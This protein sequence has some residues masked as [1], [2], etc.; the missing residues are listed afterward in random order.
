MQILGFLWNL[1][2][3]ILQLHRMIAPIVADFFKLFL[4]SYYDMKF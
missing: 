1:E 2:N 3:V 4:I